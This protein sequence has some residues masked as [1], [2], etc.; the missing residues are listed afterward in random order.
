MLS[1]VGEIARAIRICEHVHHRPYSRRRSFCAERRIETALTELRL[2]QCCG[3]VRVIVL[4]ELDRLTNR[5]VSALQSRRSDEREIVERRVI[6]WV[7]VVLGAH[8][9][10]DRE[11]DSRAAV[12][13][14]VAAAI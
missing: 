8:D 9:R 10:N 5:V 3:L 13:S 14:F 7:T 4:D 1:D 11:I 6:L 2:T 12:L